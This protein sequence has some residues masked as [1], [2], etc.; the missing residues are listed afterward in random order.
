MCH[1]Y[2]R[3]H[4][5][6][7]AWSQEDRD[8]AI[9]QFI[10]EQKTCHFCGT[11]SEEWDPASGGRRDAYVAALVECEGCVVRL[12]GEKTFKQELEAFAGTRVVLM[13]NEEPK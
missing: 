13:R 12:R 1:H 3:S 4:S 11:R 10:I 5:E 9:W 6:F 7:L 8:K 2:Q